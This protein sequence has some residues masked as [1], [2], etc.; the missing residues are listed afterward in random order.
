LPVSFLAAGLLIGMAVQLYKFDVWIVVLAII[1]AW[2]CGLTMLWNDLFDRQDDTTKN[3]TMTDAEH[4]NLHRLAVS[5]WCLLVLIAVSWSLVRQSDLA[6]WQTGI[7]LAQITIGVWLYNW[8]RPYYPFNNL[9]V[10]ATGASPALMMFPVAETSK[11]IVV[12]VFV[13]VMMVLTI[14]ETLKDIEDEEAD[15]QSNKNTLPLKVGSFQ[16]FR[17]VC[18]IACL[19]PWPAVIGM[20]CANR[21]NENYLL[22]PLFSLFG[23]GMTRGIAHAA[24]RM[25]G[26]NMDYEHR[27]SKNMLDVW[28]LIAVITWWFHPHPLLN[29]TFGGVAFF[30]ATGMLAFWLLQKT[31]ALYKR[32]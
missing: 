5:Q 11:P 18:W 31:G 14:R 6:I 13:S 17:V 25:S 16:A 8:V 12:G 32:W 19:S 30:I 21:W 28:L 1:Q 15:R 2:V 4:A 23:W 29:T 10:A 9:L 20:W 3:R 22:L 7:L 24:T 27:T 26:R